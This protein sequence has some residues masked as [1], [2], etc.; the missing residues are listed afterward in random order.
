MEEI[1]VRILSET[2]ELFDFVAAIERICI[3]VTSDC[4]LEE[5]LL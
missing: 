4:D 5:W 1:S 2:I 3:I